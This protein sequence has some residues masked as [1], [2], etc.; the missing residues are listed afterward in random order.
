MDDKCLYLG[1]DDCRQDVGMTEEN[2]SSAPSCG[3]GVF[4][5]ERPSVKMKLVNIWN[6]KLQTQGECTSTRDGESKEEFA[7]TKTRSILD[8][9]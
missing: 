4:S 5:D 1:I 8:S 6:S 2:R 9:G 7:L 3:D